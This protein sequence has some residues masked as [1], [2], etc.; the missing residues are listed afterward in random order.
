MVGDIVTRAAKEVCDTLNTLDVAGLSHV[1][2][3]V[4]MGVTIT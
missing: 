2:I 1:N 3:K 4:I